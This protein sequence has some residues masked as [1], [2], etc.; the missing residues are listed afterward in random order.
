MRV[1]PD[2]QINDLVACNLCKPMR[3]GWRNDDDVS[4][5][6]FAALPAN[7]LS[8]TGAWA[9][10]GGD[11]RTVSGDLSLVLNRTAGHKGSVARNDVID[12][13][14]LAVFDPK[15]YI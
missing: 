8:A 12:F 2:N 11:H 1:D 10:E 5:T 14:D 9:V 15:A 4:G 13:C 7:D 3:C 6:D